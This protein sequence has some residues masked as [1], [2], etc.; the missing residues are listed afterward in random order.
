MDSAFRCEVTFGLQATVVGK[1]AIAIADKGFETIA[2]L[3]V[4]PMWWKQCGQ[5]QDRLD[6][7]LR[8]TALVEH[9]PASNKW[10][11]VADIADTIMQSQ[12]RWST[13][14][15]VMITRCGMLTTRDSNRRA[16]I[17]DSIV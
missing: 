17:S 4:C 2:C 10:V 8:G 6:H 1:I 11:S 9:D 14:A 3:L 7:V 16:R 13:K 5:R 12:G 15:F